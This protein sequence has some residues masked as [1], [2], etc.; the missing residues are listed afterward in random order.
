MSAKNIPV[1]IVNPGA[2]DTDMNKGSTMQMTSPA[3]VAKSILTEVEKE[4]ADIIPDKSGRELYS[5]RSEEHT[6]EL[7]SH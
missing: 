3:D 5:V 6:S 4:I 7:Q 2:I 1:H